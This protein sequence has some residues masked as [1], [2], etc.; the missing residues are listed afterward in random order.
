MRNLAYHFRPTNLDN[1]IGQRHLLGEDSILRVILNGKNFLPN[2]IFFGP[3]GSGKTTLAHIIAEIHSGIFLRFNAANFKLE[4]LKKDLD[5]Y[6]DSIYKPILFIDEIHRLSTLQQDFLLPITE[7][8]SAT[9]IGATTQDPHYSINTALRSR[10]FC[11]E[12]KSLLREDLEILYDRVIAKYPPKHDFSVAKEWI[13]SH[14]HGDCRSMLNLLDIALDLDE[15][16]EV[17]KDS[18]RLIINARGVKN[19]DNHYDYIS[20]LIKSIR[21]SDC[22]ASIYYLACLISMGERP[23]FIARRLVILASE[24][25][26]NANPNALNISVSTMLSVEKIGYPEARIILSQCVIYLA[27]SPK[28]NSAYTAINEALSDTKVSIDSVPP[29]IKTSAENYKYPHDFGGYVTQSYHEGRKYVNLK[30]IGFEKTM[31]E[32]LRKI[33]RE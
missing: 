19:K 4:N 6:K 3:S 16:H 10:A 30:P 26:G 27:C 13:L 33:R 17:N 5:K 14:C 18:F 2:M 29:H 31:Q 23:E 15:R 20:A 7:D 11:F 1:F 9:L 28:S 32:W 22:D 8:G 25:I 12:F 21:G 24:D